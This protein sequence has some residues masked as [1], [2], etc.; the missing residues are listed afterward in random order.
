[1]RAPFFAL[2]LVGCSFSAATPSSSLTDAGDDNVAPPIDSASLDGKIPAF[3]AGTF[4]KICVDPPQ[5]PRTL[6]AATT[7]QI[8]TSISPLCVPYTATPNIDACVITGQSITIPGGN[9]ISVVSGNITVDGKSVTGTKRLILLATESITI[10]GVLDAAGHGKTS[11]PAGSAGPCGAGTKNPTRGFQGGGGWGGS[12]GGAGKNGGDGATGSGGMAAARFDATTLRGGCPGSDGADNVL[13]S[14]GGE[15]GGGGGAVLLIANQTITIDG[16]LNASGGK[17]RGGQGGGGGG[18]GGSGGMIVLDASTVNTPGKCFAN[19]GGGGEGANL[20]NGRDGGESKAP[21]QVADG[22]KGGPAPGGDG[23][24]GGFGATD[25]LSGTNGT[26]G[27]PGGQDDG[28]GGG[29]GGGVGII[30]VFADQ[31]SGTTD[32]S[33]VA[34]SPVAGS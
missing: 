34:P 31:Q 18:G 17:G 11:G 23:G 28:G 33:K 12:F 16:T 5:A 3:C 22:G 27:A 10:S 2:V 15:R 6:T 21:N 32:P 29:G 19:G 20:T 14:G 4:V 30:K 8:D 1:M 26:T 13:G 7:P 24:D 25:G 9:T